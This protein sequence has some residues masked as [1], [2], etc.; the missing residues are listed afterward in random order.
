[1]NDLP[2]VFAF[3]YATDLHTLGLVIREAVRIQA[4]RERNSLPRPSPPTVTTSF[5]NGGL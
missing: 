5:R 1:M 4:E 3:L 2:A